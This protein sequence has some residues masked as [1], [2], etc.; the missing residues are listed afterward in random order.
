[1]YSVGAVYNWVGVEVWWFL[2]QNCK[3]L[4]PSYILKSVLS[5]Y[6]VHCTLYIVH[7]TLYSAQ[8]TVQCTMYIEQCAC[9]MRLNNRCVCTMYVQCT[10][11]NVQCSVQC[12]VYSVQCTVYSVQ[13]TIYNLQFT[14]EFGVEVSWF[15]KYRIVR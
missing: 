5:E 7:C 11:Y 2:V 15:F 8:C 13:C 12:T 1:V 14:I 10:M 3:I 6:S 9:T 4:K